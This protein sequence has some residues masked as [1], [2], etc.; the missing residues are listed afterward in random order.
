[1][2]STKALGILNVATLLYF[3]IAAAAAPEKKR[4]EQSQSRFLPSRFYENGQLVQKTNTEKC[5]TAKFSLH[6]N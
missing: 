1:L 3:S 2:D 4:T 6:F 5:E